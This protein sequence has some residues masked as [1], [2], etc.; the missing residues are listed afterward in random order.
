MRRPAEEVTELLPKAADFIVA[1]ETIINE[2]VN[3]K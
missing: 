1:I 3:L 2:Q